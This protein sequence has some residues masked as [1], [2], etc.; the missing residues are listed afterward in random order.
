MQARGSLLEACGA[1]S[2]QSPKGACGGGQ[3]PVL[4]LILPRCTHVSPATLRCLV[5]A[6]PIHLHDAVADEAVEGDHY[7]FA[8]H[9]SETLFAVWCHALDYHSSSHPSP[10]KSISS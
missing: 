2:E 4:G 9:A 8:W 3:P 5:L 10:V 6:L 1:I 7:C